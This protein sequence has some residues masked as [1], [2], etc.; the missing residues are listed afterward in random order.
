MCTLQEQHQHELGFSLWALASLR[1]GGEVQDMS[2]TGVLIMRKARGSLGA[3][4]D[5]HWAFGLGLPARCLFT[6]FF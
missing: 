4:T 1:A 6:F 2:N 5:S 3:K